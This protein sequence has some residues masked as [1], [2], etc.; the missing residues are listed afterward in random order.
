MLIEKI[1][2]YRN[3]K[4]NLSC[5]ETIIYASNEEYDL[6]LDENTL[7][8]MAP[9]SGGMMIEDTCGA[10]TGSLAVLGI[11]F[12][13][14]VAH[15]SDLLKE[16]VKEFFIRFEDILYSRNCSKLK[17]LHRTDDKGC[18]DIIYK[19]GKILDDLVKNNLER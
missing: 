19:A 5:S 12:T 14:D 11:L 10:I 7:K 6:N 1:K 4:Y 8:T 15:K 2:K 9:F 3:S 18:N 13:E 17:E 16:L